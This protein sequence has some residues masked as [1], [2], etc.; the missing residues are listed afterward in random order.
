MMCWDDFV[1]HYYTSTD[2][3]S[4]NQARMGKVNSWIRALKYRFIP[5]LKNNSIYGKR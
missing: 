4:V 3:Y 5:D 1:L 2:K